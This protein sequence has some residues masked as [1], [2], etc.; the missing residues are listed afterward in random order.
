MSTVTA[1]GVDGDRGV[2][3]CSEGTK[4]LRMVG[5]GPVGAVDETW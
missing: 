3:R 1:V 5:R 2:A 4:F